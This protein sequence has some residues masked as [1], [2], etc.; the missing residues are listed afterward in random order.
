MSPT[1][2]LRVFIAERVRALTALNDALTA[3]D[4]DSTDMPTLFADAVAADRTQTTAMIEAMLHAG[5]HPAQ[6]RAVGEESQQVDRKALRR[7]IQS[8]FV[9]ELIAAGRIE[10]APHLR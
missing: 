10:D 9:G 7:A 2:A 3:T 8:L 5:R 6:R 1:E 4:H